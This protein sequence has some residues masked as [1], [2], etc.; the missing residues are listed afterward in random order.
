[1]EFHCRSASTEPQDPPDPALHDAINNL[2]DPK[3]L[4][5]VR[6]LVE[7]EGADIEEQ[8][9]DGKSPLHLAIEWQDANVVEYLLAAG[10][11]VNSLTKDFK[12]AIVTA[13]KTTVLSR[14]I[15][16]PR[17]FIQ[18]EYW[19]ERKKIVKLLLKHGSNPN[20]N[21]LDG[22]SCL[23]LAVQSKSWY[24]A[25]LLLEAGASV[26]SRDF[27]HR[28]PLFPSLIQPDD[29]TFATRRLLE[30]G[31]SVNSEDLNGN[32]ILSTAVG[33]VHNKD[34]LKLLIKH[35]V[36]CKD[37]SAMIAAAATG[38]IDL[39]K[40]LVSR[41]AD[42]NGKNRGTSVLDMAIYMEM[43]QTVKYLL[44]NGA[45]VNL[46]S[47]AH[48]LPLSLAH[49]FY[50]KKRLNLAKAMVFLLVRH[51]AVLASLGRHVDPRNTQLI[52]T[53]GYMN[54]KYEACL[55]ELGAMRSARICEDLPVTCLDVLARRNNGLVKSLRCEQVRGAFA[56]K[57]KSNAFAEY[58]AQ[59]AENYQRGVARLRMIDEW[60]LLLRDVFGPVLPESV[61]RQICEYLPDN[62][63]EDLSC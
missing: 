57:Y 49:A 17:N 9:S 11:N 19:N 36:N 31:A 28:T 33:S 42:V 3:L 46:P 58:G 43:S 23:Y 13:M 61:T 12:T 27:K 8:D 45:D 55:V 44:A 10:A 51:V 20:D 37:S 24:I 35:G 63:F 6:Q 32:T 34:R 25:E 29:S 38:Q 14:P 53:K 1:M 50:E 16:S 4:E 52:R 40:F 54:D 15:G 47:P 39:M 5:R 21:N 18:H 22:Q 60:E 2:E 56:A 62:D 30:L 48:G 26:H 59:L 41:G 7:S